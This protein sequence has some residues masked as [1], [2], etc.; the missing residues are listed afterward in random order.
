MRRRR[1]SWLGFGWML[2]LG[3]GG[4]APGGD[5]GSDAPGQRGEG[6]GGVD[7]P[8][9]ARM[10]AQGLEEPGPY[11]EKR[12]SD[13]FEPDAPH[14]LTLELSAP[15]GELDSYS[16]WGGERIVPLRSVD[17]RLRQAADDPHVQGLVLRM[18]RS[19]LDFATAAD[20]RASLQSFKGD[21][22]R[23]LLCHT[24]SIAN[25]AYYVLTVC[26]DIGLAPLGQVDVTGPLATSI[27]VRGLL[28]RL[29]VYADFLHVGDYK[30][31]AEPLTLDA[32]SPQTRETLEAVVAQSHRTLVEGM[33]EGRHLS[34]Q[35]AE[36]TIDVGVFVGQ[37]A[38]EAK[39]VD[40][41]ASWE[42]YL[43]DR[44]GN[45]PWKRLESRESPFRDFARLQRFLGIL[46][47]KRPSA[48][49]VAVVY[50][51]GNVVDGEGGGP[52]GAREEIA[53]RTLVP[54]LHA[55][56]QDDAVKAVV[57]RVS[58]PG[59]SALAS[60]QIWGAVDALSSKK[61]VVVSMGA[62]AASGGYYIACGAKKIFAR[63][64]TLTGSIGVV[65]GK[66]VLGDALE[67]IGVRTYYIARGKHADMWLP[68]QRWDDDER[69]LV[70]GLMQATY[71][72]FIDRVAAGR[73]F[74]RARV[75]EIAQGRVWTG[76]AALE[77]GLVDALGGLDDALAEA[78]R[79]GGLDPDAPI[80]VY[81]P[82]PTLRDIVASLG[83]VQSPLVTALG[84]LQADVLGWVDPRDAAVVSEILRTITDLRD[85][86]VWAVSFLVPPR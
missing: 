14:W 32:P 41:I 66:L 55:L 57:L 77:R 23:K 72:T 65:G 37:A 69:A 47:P 11:E 61:P 59:G 25:A 84:A 82:E 5:A 17:E 74:D 86:E 29:G 33:V 26:D 70:Q 3:C 38:I 78:R 64:D 34:P 36:R 22:D 52:I 81:P 54:A 9:L 39:L 18:S 76:A 51:V 24:E 6:G 40:A 71:D 19:A 16:L 1:S 75:Q 20:L 68:L 49:H 56:A 8:P 83:R 46:P 15:I 12:Q 10:F 27:H 53:S 79:L 58:S 50:A 63:P 45:A 60:E 48:P 7:M 31:A 43:L 85:A 13:D 44:T 62:V 30:G 28:D 67:K 73:S 80:E 4:G 42:N 21:G 2:A 35:D